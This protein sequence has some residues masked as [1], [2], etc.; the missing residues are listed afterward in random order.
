[1]SE[2]QYYEFQ[3]IDR[4]L[5]AREQE[6]LRALSSRARIT[7]TSF[8]NEYNFGD[9]RGRPEALMERHF[10]LFLY[11]ANWGSR[12]FMMRLP[13]RF[14]DEAT[15]GPYCHHDSAEVCVAGDS[16]ILDLQRNELDSEWIDDCSGWLAGLAEVRNE[17]LRGDLRCLYLGWLAGVAG[18]V[19]DDTEPEPPRPPGL[20]RLSA[21]LQRLANF[22]VLSPDLLAAGAGADD[23]EAPRPPEPADLEA[24][25]R[26]LPEAEKTALLLR[27]VVGDDRLLGDDLR[28]RCEREHAAASG[29]ATRPALSRR[30]AGDLRALAEQIEARRSRKEAERATAARD[31][32]LN[33]LAGREA[34]VWAKADALADGKLPRTYDEAVTLI[35]D[36]RDLAERNGTTPAFTARLTRFHERHRAKTSLRQRLVRAGL[37]P[38]R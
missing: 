12:R 9:F 22:L 24:F 28:R 18:G 33:A 35:R 31:R 37:A 14:L 21:P 15:A 34:E 3:A 19:I 10:D 30:T 27:A 4:P 1:M 6:E 38:D 17:L 13:R 23:T 8:V 26:A 11:V 32:Q 5:S 20:A 7:A 25:V 29:A 36:L 16:V 2:Y